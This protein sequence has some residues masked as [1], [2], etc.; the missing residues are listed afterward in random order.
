MSLAC[1]G[2]AQQQYRAR[3]CFMRLPLPSLPCHNPHH[4]TYVHVDAPNI[5]QVKSGL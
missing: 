2:P 5:Y 3:E 4:G 1:A